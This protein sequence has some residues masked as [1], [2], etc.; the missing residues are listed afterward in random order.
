M[1]AKIRQEI[2]V[3]RELLSPAHDVGYYVTP[4]TIGYLDGLLRDLGLPPADRH[5]GLF[6]W[7]FEPVD[8]TEYRGILEQTRTAGERPAAS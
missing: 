7:L 2:E 1:H 3:R 4:F 6:A 5:R 8:P